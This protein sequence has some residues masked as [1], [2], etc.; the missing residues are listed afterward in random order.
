MKDLDV[1]K[2][3]ILSALTASLHAKDYVFHALSRDDE[4][5]LLRPV[6]QLFE[7]RCFDFTL[8]PERWPQLNFKPIS[9]LRRGQIYEAQ[10]RFA[11]QHSGPGAF[12]SVG[13]EIRAIDHLEVRFHEAL[14]EIIESH[15]GEPKA[16]CVLLFGAASYALKAA[17]DLIRAEEVMGFEIMWTQAR[18]HLV[19]SRPWNYYVAAKRALRAALFP[20]AQGEPNSTRS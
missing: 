20:D 16:R 10:H 18:F 4:L 12:A 9:S 2:N 8:K 13:F 6:G 1:T 15:Y 14:P 19:D 11:R 5:R 17:L 7:R 3:E